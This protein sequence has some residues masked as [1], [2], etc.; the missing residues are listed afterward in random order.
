MRQGQV[1]FDEEAYI[2]EQREESRRVWD[3]L[4]T[5]YPPPP[6]TEAMQARHRQL[7]QVENMTEEQERESNDL[8]E[9]LFMQGR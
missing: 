7:C 9:R 5:H 4:Y 2:R 8:F 1:P 6:G 3:F